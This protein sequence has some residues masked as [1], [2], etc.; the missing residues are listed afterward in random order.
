MVNFSKFLLTSVTNTEVTRG[1]Y[2]VKHSLVIIVDAYVNGAWLKCLTFICL[3]IILIHT[4][5]IGKIWK[6]CA[7]LI[8][9]PSFHMLN[10]WMQFSP[11]FGC[12]PFFKFFRRSVCLLGTWWAPAGGCENKFFYTAQW[13]SSRVFLALCKM[14]DSFV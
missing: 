10:F 3:K 9:R 4:E 2:F 14:D 5:I 6:L 11:D 12:S 1:R 13:S 8:S 7:S